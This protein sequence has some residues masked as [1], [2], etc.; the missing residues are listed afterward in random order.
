MGSTAHVE[1]ENMEL[2]KYVHRLARLEF[3]LMDFVEGGI[4]VSNG[5]E[6]SP[7]LEVNEKHDKDTIFL[8]LKVNVHKQRVFAFE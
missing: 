7:V 1:E 5:V 3:R 2:S 6:S 4:V 8:D